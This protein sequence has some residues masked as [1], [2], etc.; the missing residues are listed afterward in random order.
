M[1]DPK[2][3]THE[4]FEHEVSI[5]NVTESEGGPISYRMFEAKVRCRDC[6]TQFAFK[7]LPGG[8]SPARPM[9]SPFGEELRAPIEPIEL[10]AHAKA[11]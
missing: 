10:P 7:G 1:T 3:C 9:V 4:N 5:T 2:T 6:K 8:M 11:N